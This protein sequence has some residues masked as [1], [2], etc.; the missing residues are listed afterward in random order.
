[1]PRFNID[2]T[3]VGEGFSIPPE[4]D[5]VCKVKTITLEDGQKGKYLKWTLVIGTG[6]EKGSQVFHNTTLVPAGLFNLRNTI[7]AC[8]IDVPKS[9]MQINTDAYIGKIVGITVSHREYEK[10]G[11]KKKA[12]QVAEIYRVVK[13]DK[14]FVRA[15]QKAKEDVIDN[16]SSST[17]EAPF[18][19]DD[20]A[21]E[22]DI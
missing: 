6:P 5:Y 8:G 3:D 4:G 19:V 7:M 15:D 22:I 17:N 12:A 9:T 1:M 10:D 2:F 11:Q 20:D 14:G 21:D 18:D 16:L 13:G